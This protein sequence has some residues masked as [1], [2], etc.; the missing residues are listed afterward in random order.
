MHEALRQYLQSGNESNPLETLVVVQ[1]SAK[2]QGN[3]QATKALL[4]A[5]LDDLQ[6]E[7][8]LFT[9]TVTDPSPDPVTCAMESVL[10]SDEA[11]TFSFD[12]ASEFC[13]LHV[14]W[15]IVSSSLR[16]FPS[17]VGKTTSNVLTSPD[18]KICYS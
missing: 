12:P 18:F 4:L 7:H 16:A 17:E 11:S 10:P 5:L 2:T 15:A 6:A 14:V 9:L 13:R 3:I 8:T 1:A